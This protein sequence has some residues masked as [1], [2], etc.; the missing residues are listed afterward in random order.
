MSCRL[1]LPQY[2]RSGN[3]L[4]V[5][6]ESDVHTIN[7]RS[8]GSGECSVP[9]IEHKL[10]AGNKLSCVFVVESSLGHRSDGCLNLDFLIGVCN[11]I[12]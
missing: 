9:G 8:V 7:P 10:V 4:V 2:L 1:G 6:A 3:P 12:I 5:G 11:V